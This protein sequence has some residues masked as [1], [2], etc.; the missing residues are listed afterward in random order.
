MK[1]VNVAVPRESEEEA[2]DVRESCNGVRYDVGRF[3][4]IGVVVC[5]G[6]APKE[7]R[8]AGCGEM[9]DVGD[10]RSRKTEEGSRTPTELWGL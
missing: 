9:T 1:S 8:E 7:V 2:A 4:W 3:E 10:R 6:C 5:D